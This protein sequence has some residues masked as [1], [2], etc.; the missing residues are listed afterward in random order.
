M[1][2][3]HRKRH[4]INKNTNRNRN[5]TMKGGFMDELSNTLSVWSDNI[6]QGASDLWQKTKETAASLTGTST[7]NT[8]YS[9]N[10]SSSY[11]PT[12]LTSNYGGKRR[13]RKRHMKGGFTPFLI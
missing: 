1:P 9:S 10:S 6:S 13:T 11:L 4:F 12:S 7:P 8:Y 2:R 5:R 3:I